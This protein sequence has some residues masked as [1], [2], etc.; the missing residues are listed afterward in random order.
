[1]DGYEVAGEI[2]QQ[3]RMAK[4]QLISRDWLWQ[5]K[6]CRRVREAGFDHHL[7][8]PVDPNEPLFEPFNFLPQSHRL[9]FLRPFSRLNHQGGLSF[10]PWQSLRGMSRPFNLGVHF[11]GFM[12]RLLDVYKIDLSN[13]QK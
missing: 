1:M 13:D 7:S 8:K 6:N 3:P 10:A 11:A 2:R 12:R 4:A 5:R 9:R